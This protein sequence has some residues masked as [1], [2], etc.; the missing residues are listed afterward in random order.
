MTDKL[1][2]SASYPD[3]YLPPHQFALVISC[4]DVRLLDDLV[5]FLGHDNLTNR[6]YHL[7]FAGASL[8]FSSDSPLPIADKCIKQLHFDGWMAMLKDHIRLT[9]KL[10][11]KKLS[12]VYIVEHRD[13]GAYRVCLG[14]D[15]KD[16]LKEQRQEFRMHRKYAMSLK[17]QL[18][19]IFQELIDEGCA[20]KVPRVLSFLMD[21]RGDVLML[22]RPKQAT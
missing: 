12:D 18:K 1:D 5:R 9:L 2:A 3:D 22:D 13:C 21:L 16:S 17:R 20:D 8:A 4:V 10:T 6:Y 15:F 7:T 11:D 19:T 14:V